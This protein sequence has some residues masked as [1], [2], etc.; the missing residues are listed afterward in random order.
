VGRRVGGRIG[1]AVDP[2]GDGVVGAAVVGWGVQMGTQQSHS[3][4]AQSTVRFA[5]SP[6]VHKFETLPW[7]EFWAKLAETRS[8]H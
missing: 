3:T 8:A 7:S 4:L 5:T 6:S 2:E 1:V